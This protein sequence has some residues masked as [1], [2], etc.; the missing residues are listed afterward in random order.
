MGRYVP[1]KDTQK[2]EGPAHEVFLDAYYID[3]YEV[4]NGGY[5]ECV[6]AGVCKA[7]YS[8]NTSTRAGAQ[9]Y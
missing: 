8:L 4:T 3:E 2:N 5:K 7:P 9:G 6:D 1:P